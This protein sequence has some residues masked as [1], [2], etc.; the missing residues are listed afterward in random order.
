MKA[1]ELSVQH[2]SGSEAGET[3][4]KGGGMTPGGPPASRNL[5]RDESPQPMSKSAQ[6]L[7]PAKGFSEE[8]IGLVSQDALDRDSIEKEL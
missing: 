6:A 5:L 8:F 4:T 7:G 1:I 2:K 3:A